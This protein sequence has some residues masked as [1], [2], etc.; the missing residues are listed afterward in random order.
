MARTLGAVVA[1]VTLIAGVAAVYVYQ[2]VTSFDVERVTD[3][4]VVIRGFGGNVAV[5]GTERGAVVV[6]TMNFRLQ[7]DQL[8]ELAA[9]LGGGPW[10]PSGERRRVNRCE[11]HIQYLF[12]SYVRLG[13]CP[14]NWWQPGGEGHRAYIRYGHWLYAPG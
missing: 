6:D 2:R 12:V 4:V 10:Q 8:R 9:R 1:A 7:G 3:D 5:L 11:I 14:Y 13:W